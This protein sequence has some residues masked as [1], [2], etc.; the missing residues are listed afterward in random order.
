MGGVPRL[1]PASRPLSGL[2]LQRKA[3]PSASPDLP[4]SKF[5]LGI[6]EEPGWEW[7]QREAPIQAAQRCQRPPG[8][9]DPLCAAIGPERAPLPP[10][11][12]RPFLFHS[13]TRYQTQSLTPKE[14]PWVASARGESE[15][16]RDDAVR[17]R[18]SRGQLEPGLARVLAVRVRLPSRN[19]QCS[20]SDRR[21]HLDGQGRTFTY[22]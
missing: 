19:F 14:C 16:Q 21:F 2:R 1:A 9:G 10:K 13:H 6:P 17:P 15:A 18:M 5:E 22:F 3:P 7:V 20:L 11:Y 4:R 8:A 12:R